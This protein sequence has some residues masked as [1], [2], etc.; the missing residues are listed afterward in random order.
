M[1]SEFEVDLN[2]AGVD[3][4][5]LRKRFLISAIVVLIPLLIATVSSI[6]SLQQ[7]VSNNHYSA[8]FGRMSGAVFR[9]ESSL[10]AAAHSKSMPIMMHTRHVDEA[11]EIF[12]DLLTSYSALLVSDPDRDSMLDDVEKFNPILRSL[13]ELTDRYGVNPVA[14]NAT[15]GLDETEMPG[16]LARLWEPESWDGIEPNGPSL[17][18]DVARVLLTAAQIFETE[19]PTHERVDEITEQLHD[20]IDAN[21]RLRLVGLGD[22]L[23]D[24][25]A[26]SAQLPIYLVLAI[27]G[28]VAGATLFSIFAIFRPLERTVLSA[29]SELIRERQNALVAE[30]AKSEFL[31]TMSHE[32]RT[33]LNGVLGM[34]EL[35][36]TTKLDERQS[37]FA[38]IISDSGRLLLAVITDILDFSKIEAGFLTVDPRPFKLSKLAFEPARLVAQAAEEKGIELAVRMQPGLPLSVVGDLG[39]LHQMVT[40]LLSNAVKFTDSG[41]IVVDISG[42]EVGAGAAGGGGR[43][44]ALRVEIR[45]TGIGIAPDQ[46]ERVFNRF[47]QVDSSSTRRHEGSGL[48]LSIVR[49]LVE[50]MGGQI[51]VESSPDAGSTFWFTL[52]L[53]IDETAGQNGPNLR[54]TEDQTLS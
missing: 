13:S 22:T 26:S 35:L 10:A 53:P 33:P 37:M 9:L 29:Q 3:S 18:I 28:L 5:F 2:A 48:G 38:D 42:S 30:R 27:F 25:T 36:Q 16:V 19:Q 14:D 50:L 17:E 54:Y 24:I 52:T 40:N 45:D 46:M 47:S 6:L 32:I 11:S 43:Q 51:G 39:R 4:R 31:A 12:V 34:A 23:R 1:H 15:M 8:V 7:N 41:Q 21:L 20:L 49:G 44:I